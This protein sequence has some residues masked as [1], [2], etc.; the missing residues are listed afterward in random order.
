[1]TGGKQRSKVGEGRAAAQETEPFLSSGPARIR[2][3]TSANVEP[4]Q[5]RP[6]TSLAS[7]HAS[8]DVLSTPVHQRYLFDVERKKKQI[9][10]EPVWETSG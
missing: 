10:P 2:H 1:M 4:E 7:S 6:N 8:T 9:I 5:G 3:A